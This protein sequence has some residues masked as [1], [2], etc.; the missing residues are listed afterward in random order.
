MAMIRCAECFKEISD[1]APV[2]IHCGAPTGF[3]QLQPPSPPIQAEPQNNAKTNGM[4]LAGLIT[5]LAST[6]LNILFVVGVV[7]L[8][9]SLIGFFQVEEKKERGK[10]MAIA[11]I[12]V[13]MAS[14]IYSF[15]MFQ[16]YR[17][18]IERFLF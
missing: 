2:C 17:D 12:L 1:K 18:I 7:G 11:G 14:I 15:Y 16:Q 6:V 9:L 3:V 8:I 13:S 10:G 4:A 5:A